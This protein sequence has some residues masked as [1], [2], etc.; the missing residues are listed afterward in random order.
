MIAFLLKVW[1]LTKPYRGRLFLGVITGIISGLISP[2]FIITV[3]FVY[4]A[5]FPSPDATGVAQLPM[6]KMPE[7][8]Q[9]WFLAARAALESSFH[10]HPWTRVIFISAIP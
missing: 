2:L 9:Q 7:F 5:A 10:E 8:A 4:S 1:G 6:H 3:M